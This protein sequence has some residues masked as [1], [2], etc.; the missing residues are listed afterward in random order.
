VEMAY[1]VGET[2][3]SLQLDRVEEAKPQAIVHWGDGE[4]GARVL[5]AMRA[6]GMKQP[7]IT[8]DRC[9]SQEFVKIAGPNAEGVIGAYPWDPTRQ[10]PK[11]EAF[12]AAF[13]Q[14]FGAEAGTYA[15]HSYDGMNMLI[16][17]I[18]Q[19]GLNRAKIRDVL[20][21]RSDPWTGVTGDIPLSAAL[22]DDGEVFLALRQHGDWK[23]QSR[24]DLGIPRGKIIEKPRTVR[25]ETSTR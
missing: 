15:A 24:A 20:A 7:F 6:R 1:R 18:Q 21:Y 13:R 22:D 8:C 17:A 4:D 16:W 10:D 5:N 11:L 3:F 25:E 2:N 14:S 19:A 23:F 12:R 9:V